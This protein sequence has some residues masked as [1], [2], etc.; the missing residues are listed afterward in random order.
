MK[1]YIIILTLLYSVL[2]SFAYAE[3]IDSTKNKIKESTGT[4]VSA[5][6]FDF[7]TTYDT[8]SVE[9]YRN[10]ILQPTRLLRTSIASSKTRVEF[11]TTVDGS[12]EI[13]LIYRVK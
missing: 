13:L 3:I 9:I 8:S 4:Y 2:C 5:N 6:V 12:D 7:D 1:R 11:L 10:G